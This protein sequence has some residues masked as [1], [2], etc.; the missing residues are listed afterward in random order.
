[1]TVGRRRAVAGLAG[2]FGAE[3]VRA[4]RVGVAE[5]SSFGYGARGHR[6]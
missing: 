5:V 3:L 4:I 1:V 2:E 6:S